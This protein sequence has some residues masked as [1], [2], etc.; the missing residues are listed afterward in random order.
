MNDH[1]ELSSRI[2]RVRR[3]WF[4]Q[5]ALRTAGRAACAVAIPIAAAVLVEYA[6][7]PRGA[8]LVGLA[9]VSASAS[10]ALAGMVLW[11]M[12]RRPS[13][14]VV[15]RYIEERAAAAADGPPGDDAIVSAVDVI[16][17]A[18]GATLDAF[19]PLIVGAALRRLRAID[20]DRVVPGEAM[21]RA[22][23]EAAAGSALLIGA[24]VVAVPPLGRAVEAARVAMFPAT[25]HVDV[26]PGNVRVAAGEPLR[27]RA[28]VRSEAGALTQFTPSLV[29]AAGAEERKVAMAA[30][31]DG[32]EFGFES[33]DRSFRYRVVAGSATSSEYSVT[34]LF[35]PRV[36]RIDLR[37]QYP[38][39][40]G[41][42]VR[43]EE[44]G[45]DVYAPVGTRV[46]FRILADKQVR[47]GAIAFAGGRPLALRAV[48]DKVLEGEVVLAAE[49]S[50]RIKLADADGLRSTDDTEYFIRLMDDR[51]PDVR[52][53]RPS[54]DRQITPLEEV[55]IEARADD[56]YGIAAFDLVY[57]VSGGPERVV[58]FTRVTGTGVQKTGSVLL[59]AEDLKV[60]P[61]DVITYYA[62]ARDIGRGRRASV[63]RS[64]MFF[65]EV[66][67]FGEE[68]V[69]AQSQAMGGGRA[70]AQLESLIAAQKEIINAT[71][72]IERRSDAGRSA[73]DLKTIAQAQAELKAR[74]EQMAGRSRR[75]GREQPPQRLAAQPPRVPQRQGGDPVGAAAAAMAL[76]QKELEGQRT[77]AAIPHEMA[78]LNGLLQ[79]QAEIR[80]R[81]VAQQRASGGGG[82][83]NRTTQDLSAL[84]DRELQRQQRTNYE[85]RS[86]IDERPEAREPN[87]SALD[88]IRDLAR[89]QEDLSRR[90]RELAA[91]SL[92]PEEM[93]RRLERLTRE[94]ME[95]R[96]QAEELARQM[97]QQGN[98]AQQSSQPS[99]QRGQQ[100]QARPG[101]SQAGGGSSAM[102]GVSERMQ[103]AARELERQAADAAAKSGDRAAEQLRRLEGQMR[104]G[105]ASGRQRAAG[106]IQ[107]EAQQIAEAQRRIADEAARLDRGDPAATAD[108]RRRLAD[109]KERL[110]DRVDELQRSARQLA[111]DGAP[112]ADQAGAKD[113]ARELERQQI[114]RR[115]RESAGEIRSAAPSGAS[116]AKEHQ[117]AQALDK[118]VEKFGG[119]ATAEARRLSEQLNETREMRDR[120]NRLEQQVRDAE[121]GDRGA[122]GRT[123]RGQQPSGDLQRLRDQYA[124]ELERARQALGRLGE[125]PPRDG[126]GG[127]TPERHEFSRSAPGTEAFKQDRAAWDSL[128]KEIDSALER[129]EAAVSDRLARK[130]AEDRLSAGGSDRVPESYRQRIARYYQSLA[131]K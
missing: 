127:A 94:Q 1:I 28:V 5:V 44:D 75:F 66:K 69:E 56:D 109:E 12:Q 100:A 57:S 10:L 80:R 97:S 43:D 47:D 126:R 20:S 88:R 27:I 23:V 55:A 114:G 89:R 13:D 119:A 110:A 17:G 62:R 86:Q 78:A 48:G 87:D 9:L 8:A 6:W 92:P 91:A 19:R 117:I 31:G 99:G 70:E 35:A 38:S 73:E 2:D 30:R 129:Y 118:V 59:P 130:A 36:E 61:G 65:L 116:A 22:A 112:S 121:S 4:T 11:R 96:Q 37:Y 25:V 128:R 33:V 79:A 93:K 72:N 39:F 105:S 81:Q 21:R 50:Y 68:F 16:A 42:P 63:A 98:A 7:Q 76:A 113:A 53:L 95:L 83:S 120:L 40:S 67:P 46:R 29:V 125:A 45:G 58:P 123:G 85:T 82:G 49:D 15:A 71:W 41:L 108:A 107:L 54:S 18:R 24:L 124:R 111:Q 32:F 103:S 102:R 90:Q 131:K 26:L 64:D 104:D 122:R 77:K 14:R 52:I 51:P 106:E 3:R 60:A 34:A 115:M 84:F 101:E 74:V